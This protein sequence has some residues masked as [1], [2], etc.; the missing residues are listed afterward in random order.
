MQRSRDAV[1]QVPLWML[2]VV[3]TV[4]LM[5]VVP[6]P[7]KHI[8]IVLFT[9]ILLATAV[10]PAANRLHR[11]GIPRTVSI[12]LMY[13]LVVAIIA[14][15]ISLLVPL[16]ITE[17]SHVQERLPEYSNRLNDVLARFT[18]KGQTPLST[19]QIFSSLSGNLSNTARYLGD[20]ALTIA[21]LLVQVLVILVA[22]YF[23][24]VDPD[25]SQ[26]LV[27]RFFAPASRHR[28]R[29][30]LTHIGIRLGDWVRAQIVLAL[31]FGITFGSS[32]AIMGVPYA[33]TLGITG[34]V[35]EI[36]PYVGGFI[37]VIL[38]TL[39]A[40]TAQPWQIA[41]VIIAYTVVTNIEAHIVEPAVMGRML[42]LHPLTVV[43]S[44]FIGGETLGILGA[45]LSVPFAVVIQVLID[46]MY[47]SHTAEPDT[48][49]TAATLPPATTF[50]MATM[51][52]SPPAP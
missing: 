24:A 51:E 34:A 17:L 1:V 22:A 42:G 4:L 32:L 6:L 47:A 10:A 26:H 49:L 23:F 46:E 12:L 50:E 38:A 52:S 36:I 28:V 16:V 21:G 2:I 9:A 35:L 39:V 31:F 5:Q 40:I 20:L 30:L 33:L 19:D 15:T 3:T 27:A 11:H 7:F 25:F 13:L 41:G 45:L 18:A 44:L 14:G 8:F 29:T 43:L 48:D 37:T